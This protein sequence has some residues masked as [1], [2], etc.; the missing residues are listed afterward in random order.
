M[1]TLGYVQHYGMG[2][3]IARKQLKA[4]GLPEPEFKVHD[5]HVQVTIKSARKPEDAKP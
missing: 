5:N 1:R 2:I 3:P 4:T